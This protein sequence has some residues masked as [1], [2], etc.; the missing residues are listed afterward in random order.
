MASCAVHCVGD[1]HWR[2][3]AGSGDRSRARNKQ[4]SR[5]NEQNSEIS[6]ERRVCM[7]IATHQ[8]AVPFCLMLCCYRHHSSG[9][10]PSRPAVVHVATGGARP[11]PPPVRSS[12]SHSAAGSPQH[13]LPL[14]PVRYLLRVPSCPPVCFSRAVC[15]S[16]GPSAGS[17]AAGG[18]A[19]AAR[20]DGL[21]CTEVGA[22]LLCNTT[23]RPLKNRQEPR[24]QGSG[25]GAA[26]SCGHAQTSTHHS[27]AGSVLSFSFSVPRLISCLAA[28]IQAATK[29]TN[30]PKV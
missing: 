22:R 14:H 19:E 18:G 9:L 7:H 24:R 3:S 11:P 5:R 30:W 4:T 29:L 13:H 20:P 10:S 25:R 21:S 16:I 12:V 17:R 15:W 1:G 6:S 2:E 8:H 26:A 28:R 27:V 23:L